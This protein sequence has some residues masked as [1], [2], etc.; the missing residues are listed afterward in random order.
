[1]NNFK[2]IDRFWINIAVKLQILQ[3]R[4]A[5]DWNEIVSDASILQEIECGRIDGIPDFCQT[6]GEATTDYEIKVIDWIDVGVG[7]CGPVT[8]ESYHCKLCG[9]EFAYWAYG[10]IEPRL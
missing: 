5:L 10:M 7:L 6:C 8:E 1:M 3:F 4:E 9:S 2:P